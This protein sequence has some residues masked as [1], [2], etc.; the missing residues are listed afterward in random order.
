MWR[1]VILVILCVEFHRAASEV[2]FAESSIAMA[3]MAV[4][5]SP[6]IPG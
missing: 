1:C 4:K 3:C 6:A 2:S 5:A